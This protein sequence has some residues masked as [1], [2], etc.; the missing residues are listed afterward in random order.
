LTLTGTN[1]AANTL[2]PIISD[3]LGIYATSLTKSG[4]GKWVLAGLNTYT[5]GTTVN[6]GTLV[7]GNTFTMSGAN[8]MS[9]AGTGTAGVNYATVSTTGALTFGGTLGINITASLSGGESFT[10]FSANGGTLS[11]NFGSTTGNVSVT[12]SYV[13]SLTNNAGIW[14][15]TDTNGS[16]LTFTFET[17]GVNAGILS[18]SAI[19]EPATYAALFGALAL[20]GATWQRRRATRR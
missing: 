8:A 4:A 18:V 13:A 20:A 14:T 16:G 15:G 7:F 1:T 11:G 12:G 5:G 3:H 2:N 6:A 10:L 9:V 17:S 19:P